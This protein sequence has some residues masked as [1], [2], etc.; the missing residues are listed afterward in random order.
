MPVPEPE[1]SLPFLHIDLR[2]GVSGLSG[3]GEEFLG[4]PQLPSPTCLSRPSA[5]SKVCQLLVSLD[6]LGR[7]ELEPRVITFQSS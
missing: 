6:K 5:P 1:L 4:L 2:N 7:K 3:P